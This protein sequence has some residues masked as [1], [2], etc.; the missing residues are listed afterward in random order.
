MNRARFTHFIIICRVLFWIVAPGF[1]RGSTKIILLL[2][3][4]YFTA[5]QLRWS[6]VVPH[7]SKYRK[8]LEKSQL[9]ST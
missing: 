2:C 4:F 9:Y 8:W 5:T 1:M 3:Y 6:H 7:H